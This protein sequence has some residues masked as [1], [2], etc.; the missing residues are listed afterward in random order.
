M[1]RSPSTILAR[2]AVLAAP[3]ALLAG[4]RAGGPA[5]ARSADPPPFKS[6][7]PFPIGTCAMSDQLADPQFA[8]LLHANFN[9]ITPEWEMK[10]EAILQQDGSLDF[11]LADAIA[12]VAADGAMGLH[13]T[14]LVWH[15]QKAPAFEALDGQKARFGAAYRDYILAV[16]GRYRGKARGWDVVNEPVRNDAAGYYDSVFSRN[17]GPGHIEDAFFLAREADPQA[18]LFLNDYNLEY[19]PQKRLLFL[20][21]AERL[22]KAGAPLGGLGSQTHLVA[23]SRTGQVTAA[24]KDLASLGLAI[25]VSELDVSTKDGTYLG[26]DQRE[27]LERQALLVAE[28]VEA[29]NALP[30]A[31]RY[32][33]TVWGVRDKDAWKSRPP[34]DGTD[35]PLLFDDAGQPK[36]AARAFAAALQGA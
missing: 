15:E 33:L 16:A 29:F 32:A 5:E 9:Q 8:R 26:M 31:Q 23:S 18:V 20:K 34:N 27:R 30:A 6:V 17:L 36:P 14:T 10:M 7:A 12:Q 3:L 25:H 1:T 13:A 4:C 11:T 22:L 28:T 21:L 2:R 24:L 19:M 35:K